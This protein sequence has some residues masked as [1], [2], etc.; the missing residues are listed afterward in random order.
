[1]SRTDEAAPWTP[2]PPLPPRLHP[3]AL[4]G[5]LLWSRP[6]HAAAREALLAF[7]LGPGPL[8]V[9]VGVDHAMCIL[10]HARRFPDTR[11]L[12]LE[13]RKRR[14]AA[15]A[16]HAPPNCRLVA[17]DA[18]A[19]L[20]LLPDGVVDR[21]DVWFPTPATDPRHLLFDA[22]FVATLARVLRPGGR[23]TVVSDVAALH[24]WIADALA[25]WSPASPPPRGPVLSR[26]ERVC[27]RDGIPVHLG[28]WSPP[29]RDL[30]SPPVGS[31]PGAGPPPR[32][33]P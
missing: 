28:S 9:E 22:A 20:P 32:R 3:R 27:R 17:G 6:E 33:D 14:I 25:A 11:W 23:L 30:L 24:A 26:R 16:P 7:A 13:L 31:D 2:P 29:P 15:A 19:V 21:V 5:S 4:H 1:M 10:D 18:R 8:A 12:G